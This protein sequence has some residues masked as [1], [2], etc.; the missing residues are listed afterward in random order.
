MSP[1]RLLQPTLILIALEGLLCAAWLLA[2][3]SDPASAVALG[4]SAA[5]LALLAVIVAGALLAGGL[6]LADRQDGARVWAQSERWLKSRAA[7]VAA[8][9][10]GA[11][12]LLLVLHRHIAPAGY[13]EEISRLLP[14][15]VFGLL[16][17][18]HVLLLAF[19]A[20][21]HGWKARAALAALLPVLVVFYWDVAQHFSALNHDWKNSDQGIFITFAYEVAASGYTFTG[22]RNFMPLYPF[23]LAP[24]LDS[25]QAFFEN[26][27]IAKTFNILLSMGLIAGFF[28]LSKVHLA[29]GQALLL[30]LLA[31]FSLYIY[32]APYS[33]PEVLFYFLFFAAFLLSCRLIVRPGWKTAALLG[34]SL[35][36]A[37]LTKA[38]ALPLAAQVLTTLAGLALAAI[39][40]RGRDTGV[41]LAAPRAYLL[42]LALVALVFVAALWPY[43]SESRARYGQYFYNVNTTFYAWYD[44]WR[45]A[46]EGTRAYGDGVGWPEL[47]ADQI[48]SPS[49]YLQTHSAAEIGARFWRGIQNQASNLWNTF[50]LVSYPLLLA[51]LV[52]LAAWG[53]RPRARELWRRYWPLIGLVVLMWGGY[54]LAYAWYGPIADY[55]DQRFTYSLVLPMLFASFVAMRHLLDGDEVLT[56]LG[57]AAAARVW[58]GRAFGAI[59]VVL[60]LDILFWVPVKL[61]EFGWYGK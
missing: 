33:Q 20:G 55:A 52:A 38:S 28:L 10:V 57:R 46:T 61:A 17:A 32:K 34:L 19:L 30:A 41:Q 26:F 53:N 47:P 11:A 50:S 36:A 6:A 42:S 18:G 56:L 8:L 40:R 16:A 21:D 9:T 3:P 60:A 51:A 4:L 22:G 7:F 29:R 15:A 35:A 37:H 43:I 13:V 14:L 48:P 5:R 23:L 31:A 12:S 1:R 44:T 54:L 24:L 59:A 27:D 2:L 25:S 39:L 45:E 49:R 58:R